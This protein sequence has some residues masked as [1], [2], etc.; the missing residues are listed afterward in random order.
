MR[1]ALSVARLPL[2]V[3]AAPARRGRARPTAPMPTG[4]RTR[5]SCAQ[6]ASRWSGSSSWTG[7]FPPEGS[8]ARDLR[9]ADLRRASEAHLPHPRG[10]RRQ[11]GPRQVGSAAG[12]R[13]AAVRLDPL[14]RLVRG[15]AGHPARHASARPL[16]LA[17]PPTTRRPRPKACIAAASRP[18]W[19]SAAASAWRTTSP[20]TRGR[21]SFGRSSR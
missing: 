9:R 2:R 20:S 7:E 12:G 21:S 17:Q 13:H 18:M 19:T 3:G 8:G 16:L 14:P 1:R 4:R 5:R 11:P 15:A 6:T 10:S